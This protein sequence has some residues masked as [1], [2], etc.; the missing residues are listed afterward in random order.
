MNCVAMAR[1][2]TLPS[3]R[4]GRAEI[5]LGKFSGQMQRLGIDPLDIARRV[6]V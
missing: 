6:D 4:H 2:V 3:R 5:L 1:T